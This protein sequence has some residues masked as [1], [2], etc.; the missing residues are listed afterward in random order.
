M[1]VRDLRQYIKSISKGNETIELVGSNKEYF[2]NMMSGQG[3]KID[4]LITGAASF[5]NN[6]KEQLFY[7]FVQ[8]A[9]DASADSLFFYANEEF[10]IVLNNGEPFFTDLDIFD[11]PE[12]EEPRD[13]QLYNFLAKGKSLK[14]NDDEKLG[15]YGQGSKL[16]YTLLADI[17]HNVNTEELLKEAII[18]NKKGPYLVSWQNMSQLDAWLINDDEWIPAQA[19]DVENNILFAKILMSYYPIAPGQDLDRFSNEEAQRAIKAFNELVDPPRNKSFLTRGTALI[20][21]LGMGKYNAIIEENNLENVRARLGGFASI[22]ADQE[23]NEGKSLKHI[24]VMGKEV[25]QHP[26]HSLF[27]DFVEDGNKFHYH[28]AFNPIFAEKNVVNFFK[29]LP[30]LQTKYRFGFI[31]DSQILEVDDSRQ[32]ISDT[33]KTCD[34]LRLAYTHLVDELKS[35]LVS[36][37]EKFDYIYQSLISSRPEDNS[38]D[39]QKI[40]KAFYDVIRPFLNEYAYTSEGT[41][42]PFEEV[43]E[44][45]KETNV[46]LKDIGIDN[47]HWIDA[48]SRKKYAFHFDKKVRVLEFAEMLQMAD[49]EKLS[50]WIKG[51]SKEDYKLFHNNCLD[52]ISDIEDIQVFRSNENNLYSWEELNSDINVYYIAQTTQ[53]VF[54]GQEY[55]VEP[56]C[57]EYNSDD[58]TVLFEKIKANLEDLRRT[59]MGRDAVCKTLCMIAENESDYEDEI[60]NNI[61][62]LQNWRGDYLPFSEL[63]EDRLGGTILFDNFRIKGSIPECIKKQ[64]WLIDKQEDDTALWT[65]IVNH[66]D[67]IKQ[68]EGWGADT[69]AYLRDIQ[70]AY[71]AGGVAV[72]G[73]LLRLYLDEN[74]KPVEEPCLNVENFERLSESEYEKL[75]V[76]YSD[77]NFVPYKY[78]K[79]LSTAPFMMNTLYVYDLINLN[80]VIDFDTLAILSK[81]SSDGFLLKYRVIGDDN[82]FRV[83]ALN[84]GKNYTNDIGVELRRALLEI[85]FYYIP[86]K[87]QTFITSE[88]N[89]FNITRDDFAKYVVDKISDKNLIFSLIRNCSSA[90]VEHYINSLSTISINHKISDSDIRWQIIKFA[91]SRD[92]KENEF[93]QTIFDCIR[94]KNERLPETIKDS[95]F[96]AYEHE[97]NL[98]ALNADYQEDNEHVDSFLNCL[99]SVNDG[100]WFKEQFYGEKKEIVSCKEIYG[101]IKNTALSIEQLRFCLDYSLNDEADCYSLK[102]DSKESL[103]AAL[104]MIKANQYR[105]FD[106]YFKIPGFRPESQVFAE[107]SLLNDEE[108]LPLE[109]QKWLE[110]NVDAINLF[111]NI[112]TD[113]ES[114]ISVR[115][116]IRDNE[117]TIA[118]P[119]FED[120]DKMYSTLQWLLNSKLIYVYGDNAYRNIKRIIERL[121]EGLKNMVFFRYTGDVECRE[122]S[123]DSICPTFTLEE[124]DKESCFLSI[125]SWTPIFLDMLK[126]DKNVQD[127]FVNEVVFAYEGLELLSK[128]KLH[129]APKLE[130]SVKAHEGDYKEIT[131]EP[132]RIWKNMPESRGILIKTSKKPIGINFTI[133]KNRVQVFSKVIDNKDFGYDINGLVVV[134]YPNTEKLSAIKMIEKHIA[135]MVFFQQPFIVL[136]GLYVEQLERLEQIAEE[137][138]TDIATIVQ[139]SETSRNE[140]NNA[141]TDTNL[142][143][144]KDKLKT[145]KELAESFDADELMELADKKDKILEILHDLE[146]AE[147][148]SQESQVRQTIG[149]IG[150]LIYEQYLLKQGKEYKYAAVEGVGDYDFHNITDKTYVDVKTTLYSLKEGTAPFYLHK[151]QNIFMQ[152][153]PN[154]KYHIVRISLN[155]LDLQDSYERLKGKYGKEANPLAD[156]RLNNACKKIAEKYWT[157]AKIEVFD[158]LA[159]E[160]SIKIEKKV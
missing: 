66:F 34:Q 154:E 152:K 10:L 122:K 5:A 104:S 95:V 109:M 39:E 88:T 141:N 155:D 4:A 139:T 116:Y 28:F 3:Q 57:E 72:A 158:A 29:G 114:Y 91:V 1:K 60:I 71:K 35:L 8:N 77:Y 134:Q 146:G 108:K 37:R 128:H 125:Y 159:P 100:E 123:L 97:Y 70:N 124:Y 127:F 140:G 17:N 103:S 132:Y 6:A 150:E 156:E 59:S 119:D 83:Q 90:V 138:G 41:Y 74:G 105:G 78:E 55:I 92:T 73:S 9:Y 93:R 51:M 23:R 43:C 62:V 50:V 56:M 18:N 44:E 52:C 101:K 84:G 40:R 61:A 81:I 149:Y 153:H 145:V 115:R 82:S 135:D 118:I 14:L 64:D 42:V 80:Q 89:A 129:K 21:P 15:K 65:W 47:L 53:Q 98:Y 142:K 137:K 45:E 157:G 143:V 11:L 121:P 33:E 67:D 96:I 120:S 32:R 130:V 48:D 99:P 112:R 117:E 46:L 27:V 110:Q 94:H 111:E 126:N 16:L 49:N 151:S 20:I 131:T 31:L 107:P 63:F 160:Y 87:V 76:S 106:E 144:D 136:Q 26:V 2:L 113:S 85:G 148:E 24:Y 133:L 38:E 69:D 54:I 19:D 36:N 58:Y 22:T 147:D 12:G 75:Q 25:E 79:V 13:G 68:E 102:I 30:I 7:E 86:Q